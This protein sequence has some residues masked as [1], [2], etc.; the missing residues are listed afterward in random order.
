MHYASHKPSIPLLNTATSHRILRHYLYIQDLHFN[1]HILMDS[2]LLKATV[3]LF[4]TS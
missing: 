1:D 2:V 4:L 3:A